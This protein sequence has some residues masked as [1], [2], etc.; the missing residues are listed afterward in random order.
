MKKLFTTTAFAL[1]LILN[2]C[3]PYGSPHK[4][5]DT[6]TSGKIKIAVDESYKPIIAAQID[7]FHS[8]YNDAHITPL[9]RSEKAALNALMQDSVRVAII[10]RQLTHDETGFLKQ[11]KIDPITVKVAKDAIALLVHPSKG[12]VNLTMAQ[13]KGI[14]DGTFKTWSS[15]GV[16]G[17]VIRGV[18]DNPNSS[19]ARY[20]SEKF[21]NGK[22]IPPTLFATQSTTD[23]LQYVSDNK[24]ALGIIGV[25]WV[26]DLDDPTNP[27]FNKKVGVIG[28]AN[29]AGD[30][31]FQ[32]FQAY[33]AQ[34]TY[35]LTRELFMISRETYSGLG[36]GFSIF[37]ASDKGQR[38]FL[39][40]GLVPAT[41]PIRLIKT[42]SDPNY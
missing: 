20:I 9:Y 2:G 37:V 33:I 34:G 35:P 7:V 26:S 11:Q 39:K 23:V 27:A 15:V 16:P 40:S 19:S 14:F 4:N 5:L 8:D 25:S 22:P 13:V 31:F 32:P 29:T 24:D 41:A 28:V 6:V 38:I 36:K 18:F 3:N 21:L 10:S 17:G 12:S 1:I 42:R 30:E